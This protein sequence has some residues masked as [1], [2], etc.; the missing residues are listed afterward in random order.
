MKTIGILKLSIGL[1]LSF[2]MGA[3]LISCDDDKDIERVIWVDDDEYEGLPAY[4][5]W[6]YNTFGAYVNNRTFASARYFS[7]APMH[8]YSGNDT[9]TFC[10]EAHQYS[11]Y[12]PIISTL[13]FVFPYKHI[14]KYTGLKELQG[15]VVDLAADD[16]KVRV[17]TSV[18]DYSEE[19]TLNVE[20]G[21]L[22]FS[23]VQ[24]LYIDGDMVEAIVSGTFQFDATTEGT[25]LEVRHGRFDVGVD[26]DN[27][28]F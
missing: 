10:M 5:E 17:L 2:V 20:S 22:K 23:R 8:F 21:E 6:G 13:K 24:I 9:L 26:G 4:T 3:M 19:V 7:E 18:N 16:V 27:L 28:S 25:S 11:T 14:T 12:S 1:A 15:V